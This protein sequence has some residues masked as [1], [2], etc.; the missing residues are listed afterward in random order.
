MFLIIGLAVVFASILA[1][2]LM[3]GGNIAVL[4]QYSEFIII[5]GAA[6][7]SVIIGYSPKALGAIIKSVMGL[8]KGNPYKKA[9]FLEL[10]QAMYDMFQHSRRDGLMALERH[11]EDPDTSDILANYTS[12]KNNHHAVD[13]LCD[14]LKLVVMG[15]ISVYDLS[16]MMEIDLEAQHEDAMKI[17]GILSTIGDAMP[18]FGIV[19]AVLGVVITMQAIGGPAEQVGEKVAAALV[20]TFLGVL[21]AYAIFAPLSKACENVAKCEGQ[22]MSCIKNAVVSFARG[23]NPL[24]SVEFAR[25]GIEPE[26]RPS[27]RELE[28][29]CKRRNKADKAAPSSESEQAAA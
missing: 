23:D 21:L 14:T 4:M 22:Y 28:D 2:Y 16:D 5:G 11:V 9:T 25:R 13:L 18:G 6:L 29:T 8:L 17:S 7:G 20:G 1:G 19:A 3:H 12:F 27:F 26:M 15:G 10:L 24:V